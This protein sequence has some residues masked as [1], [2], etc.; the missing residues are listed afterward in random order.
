MPIAGHRHLP[1]ECYP[2]GDPV[3]RAG[4]VVV[5]GEATRVVTAGDVGAP[6]VLL[7]HGWGASAYSF[8]KLAPVLAGAGF[9][10][11][12]PDLRGHGGSDRPQSPADYTSPAMA[13]HVAAVARALP[14]LPV[15][16]VGQSLGGAIALDLAARHPALVP[17]AVLISSIGFTHLRRVDVIRRVEPWRWVPAGAPR[18]TLALA[19]RRIHGA[20]ATWTDRDV[21]EYWAPLRDERSVTALMHLV[22]SF[23]FSLRDPD[24]VAY[25]AGRLHLIFGEQDRPVPAGEALAHA[26]R[27]RGA[28]VQ[29]LPGVGHVP[30]EEA[31]EA[32]AAA[33]MEVAAA[34]RGGAPPPR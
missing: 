27:F 29:V 5:A 30:A 26:R 8:R 19:M 10:A 13:E 31:P 1:D 34:V 14:V 33:I 11:V 25:L 4:H 32:V 15:A 21:D 17:G 3:A 20:S 24:T 22:R 18:W 2:A 12:V 23:D 9:R 6:A 16:V 7:L 28:R